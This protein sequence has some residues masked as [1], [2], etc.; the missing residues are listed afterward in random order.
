MAES[1]KNDTTAKSTGSTR[2]NNRPGNAA[3]SAGR[4]TRTA[5]TQAVGGATSVASDAADATTSRVTA[6]G[7]KAKE[8]GAF[9]STVPGRSVRIA[10]TAWTAVRHHQAIVVGAGGGL[11]A[12]L[13]GAYGLGRAGAKRGQGPLTRATGG[14]L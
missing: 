11:I 12:A 6:I 8:S 4:Q 9:L 2:K 14:R 13:A 10:S 7:T 1:A 3:Q 5:A